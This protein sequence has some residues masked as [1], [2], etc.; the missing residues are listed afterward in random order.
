MKSSTLF[1]PGSSPRW[2]LVGSQ[3]F[4]AEQEK[5]EQRVGRGSRP[6]E[7]RDLV[8]KQ[9]DVVKKGVIFPFIAP[10]TNSNIMLQQN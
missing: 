8:K 4:P 10:D 9:R 6:T 7:D 2:H 1:S 3:K 5:K